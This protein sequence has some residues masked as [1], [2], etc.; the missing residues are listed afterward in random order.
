MGAV[1]LWMLLTTGIVLAASGLPAWLVLVGTSFSFAAAGVATGVFSGALLAALPPRLL[2]LL[3]NDLLQALPLY[4]L[5]GA[6]LNRL[7]LAETLFRVGARLLRRTP[8]AP[9]LT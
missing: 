4:V 3:E 2:G 5:I 7:P 8:A 6:M 1:G 9:Y